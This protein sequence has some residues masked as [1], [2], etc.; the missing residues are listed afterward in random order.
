[1][2]RM[3][4]VAALTALVASVLV[5]VNASGAPSHH[6]RSLTIVVRGSATFTSQVDNPPAGPSPGDAFTFTGPLTGRTSGTEEGACTFVTATTAQCSI[7]GSFAAGLLQFDGPVPFDKQ[8]YQVPLTGGT[9]R[10]ARAHG[11]ADAHVANASGTVIDL[12]LRVLF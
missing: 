6:R 1:M 2:K 9:G 3:L 5:A 11:F 12:V 4:A 10:F 8:H 7:T